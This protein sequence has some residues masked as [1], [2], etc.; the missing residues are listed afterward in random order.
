MKVSHRDKIRVIDAWPQSMDDFRDTCD[1]KFAEWHLF[2]NT[3][4]RWSELNSDPAKMSNF[5]SQSAAAVQ[6]E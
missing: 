5:L 6:I 2:D 1:Q 3:S 4:N